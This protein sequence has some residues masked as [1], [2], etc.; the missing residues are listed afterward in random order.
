MEKLYFRTTLVRSS[1]LRAAINAG[2]GGVV[3]VGDSLNL[4]AAD[5]AAAEK[6]SF[7]VVVVLRQNVK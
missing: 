4:A 3:T 7:T 6:A 2:G 5:L 1:L